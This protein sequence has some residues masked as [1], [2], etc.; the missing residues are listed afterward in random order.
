MDRDR[1][2]QES[3]LSSVA[4]KPR[5]EV[6]PTLPNRLDSI[7]GFNHAES[8]KGVT[9]DVVD[10]AVTS[11]SDGSH[12]TGD[13][14]AD[15]LSP[16]LATNS[17]YDDTHQ[18]SQPKHGV[19]GRLFGRRQKKGVSQSKTLDD[20]NDA[21]G[22]PSPLEPATNTNEALDDIAQQSSD[23]DSKRVHFAQMDVSEFNRDHDEVSTPEVHSGVSGKYELSGEHAR[24]LLHYS[25][26]IDEI[27]VKIE[28]GKRNERRVATEEGVAPPLRSIASIF[29]FHHASPTEDVNK[30]LHKPEPTISEQILST[31]KSQSVKVTGFP[32]VIQ[33]REID[34][35]SVTESN[36]A[37][38]E[39]GM[40]IGDD[41]G[42]YFP[43]SGSRGQGIL[44]FSKTLDEDRLAACE[45][46]ETLST[47]A[48][49]IDK[50][51]QNR[52]RISSDN[53][54]SD[55]MEELPDPSPAHPV[56]I[57]NPEKSVFKLGML[58][59]NS[60]PG[61][62]PLVQS[63]QCSNSSRSSVK[64]ESS[65]PTPSIEEASY[66]PVVSTLNQKRKVSVLVKPIDMWKPM[67]QSDDDSYYSSERSSSDE[68]SSDC[69][70]P[71]DI[72]AMT[73]T[74]SMRRL[75]SMD[76]RKATRLLGQEMPGLTSED[77]S[78][79]EFMRPQ[80]PEEISDFS[81]R[82]GGTGSG[83]T[84]DSTFNSFSQSQKPKVDLASLGIASGFGWSRAT[85]NSTGSEQY[86]TSD[87]KHDIGNLGLAEY[88]EPAV[89]ELSPVESKS[90]SFAS[91]ITDEVK[92]TYKKTLDGASEIITPSP[93]NQDCDSSGDSTSMLQHSYSS[94]EAMARYR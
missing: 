1:M 66:E 4:L 63:R 40:R 20:E 14:L 91:W 2:E 51:V 37:S 69:Q 89:P 53:S 44:K 61:S 41:Q 85:R 27:R 68:Y 52:S 59:I 49:W 24:P 58:P 3:K 18:S 80:K 10:S 15:R 23:I 71:T 19:F 33:Q 35:M 67:V 6:K 56:N 90:K 12:L 29:G 26:T 94:N 88:F 46:Y 75:R 16:D 9:N 34:A 31:L 50:P 55:N 77:S 17:S 62:N 73:D 83:D 47:E 82:R 87:S 57:F 93:Q 38:V 84:L 42:H 5:Q 48:T 65:Q 72:T 64:L 45:E 76:A 21:V 11:C 7:F 8:V 79:Q 54:W 39:D 86:F 74:P 13:H 32:D 25:K 60:F 70:P 22:L 36:E 81:C 28:E 30:C 78:D 43:L 92:K